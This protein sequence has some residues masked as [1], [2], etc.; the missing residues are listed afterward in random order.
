KGVE[1]TEAG[2]LVEKC[3]KNI[4]K[5]YDNMIED[6][7]NVSKNNSTIRIDSVWTVATYALPCTLF[8]LK[9]KYPTHG[10]DSTANLSDDVEQNVINDTCDV[11]FIHDK[12]N[13]L[14]LVNCRVGMDKLVAV[15]SQDFNI[16]QNIN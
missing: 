3:A 9:K 14:T 12:P 6:L 5:T 11:G 4:L 7:N 2:I 16:K 10:Y 1:L 15:V 8:K 13:D